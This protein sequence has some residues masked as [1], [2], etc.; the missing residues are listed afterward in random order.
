M[1][2]MP[3]KG[4]PNLGRVLQKSKSATKKSRR[5]AQQEGYLHTTDMQDGYDWGRLNLVSVTEQD[6]YTDFMNTAE[7]AGREFDAEKWNVKLLDAQTRQVY[8]DTGPAEGEEL[9]PPSEEQMNLRIPRRPGWVG[10][11][12]EQLKEQENAAF[13]DWRREL[14]S[15]QETTT[16]MITPYEKNLE[17]WRQLWRVIERSDLVIQ[18]VDARFPLLF[19]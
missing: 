10:L 9:G 17:F 18:I 1:A 3:G 4:G 5:V 11:S 6:T 2:R 16:A 13:L 12:A 7:M 15:L 19:R 14:A 8:I